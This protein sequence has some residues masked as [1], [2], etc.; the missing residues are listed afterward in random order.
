[1]PIAIIFGPD[2]LVASSTVD[3]RR[4]HYSRVVSIMGD[5]LRKELGVIMPFVTLDR[6]LHPHDAAMPQHR[7]HTMCW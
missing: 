3:R 5:T 7:L 6:V 2:N 1:M 4:H